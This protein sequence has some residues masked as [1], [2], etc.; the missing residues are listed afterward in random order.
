MWCWYGGRGLLRKCVCTA[1]LCTLIMVPSTS[2]SCRSVD[3]RG[4]WSCLVLLQTIRLFISAWDGRCDWLQ[5][6]AE[7]DVVWSIWAGDCGELSCAHLNR[8]WQIHT[9]SH[10]L[11]GAFLACPPDWARGP[12]LLR[13]E[14]GLPLRGC[15]TIVP[16][17]QILFSRLS[18]LSSFQP[19]SGNSCNSLSVLCTTLTDTDF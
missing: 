13:A 9:T 17:L 19:W 14:R 11:I 2:S 5:T 3:Y 8:E 1:V 15:R 4:L 18:V 6:S 16:V 7:H 12:P 10:E